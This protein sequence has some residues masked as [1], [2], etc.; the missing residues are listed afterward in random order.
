MRK[1]ETLGD[2]HVERSLGLVDKPTFID[3]ML[4]ILY[5]VK[6]QRTRK[7]QASAMWG[8][9]EHHSK[10]ARSIGLEE[11]LYTRNRFAVDSK[12][13][14]VQENTPIAYLDLDRLSRVPIVSGALVISSIGPVYTEALA[15][16]IESRQQHSS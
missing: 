12:G 11:I 10:H 5:E 7:A 9:F 6:N 4:E 2:N 8:L 15:K 16:F 1:Y 14:C 13:E 3:T